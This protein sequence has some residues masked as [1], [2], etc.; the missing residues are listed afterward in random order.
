MN[1]IA[2]DIGNTNIAIGLYL[3]DEE[4]FIKSIPGQS[5]KE[6]TSCLASA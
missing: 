6:L 2:V 4:Q 1:I 3:E 5:H